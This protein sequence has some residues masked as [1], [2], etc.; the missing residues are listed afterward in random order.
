MI[1]PGQF[2]LSDDAVAD[3]LH[4]GGFGHLVTPGPETLEVT[5]MPLLYNA[6]GNVLEGHLARTNPHWRYTG[7]SESLVI[8]PGADA[9][10]SPEFYPSKSVHGKVVPTWNYE[11]LYVYGQLVAHDDEQWLR[12]HV[13]ALT[14][15]HESGRENEW[16]VTDAPSQ[17]VDAQLRGIVGIEL[18]VARVYGKAK[19]NQNRSPADRSGVIRGLEKGSFSERET[20]AAMVAAGLDNG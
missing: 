5:S 8:L 2:R 6:E 14:A 15:R 20:A 4:A 18:H 17:F 9:Y 3:S 12:A 13:T 1:L 10:V 19:L 11:V 16:K 7:T